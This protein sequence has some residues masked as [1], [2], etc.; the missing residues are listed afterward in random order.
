V[1]KYEINKINKNPHG[2]VLKYKKFR[3]LEKEQERFKEIPKLKLL[4]KI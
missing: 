1:R 2:Q 3:P 4:I